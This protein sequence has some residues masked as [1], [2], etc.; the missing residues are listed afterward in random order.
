MSDG[1]TVTS[2]LDSGI[3]V[4]GPIAVIVGL[5]AFIGV[6]WMAAQYYKF[7]KEWRNYR[8]KEKAAIKAEAEYKAQETLK[9]AK[10]VNA[11][12]EDIRK[13]VRD[14]NADLEA[15]LK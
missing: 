3:T 13:I 10:E 12:V 4:S 14:M 5:Y 1:A 6:V 8:L 2:S 11:Q 15:R 9:L 7:W